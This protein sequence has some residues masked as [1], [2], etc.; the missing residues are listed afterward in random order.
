[1]FRYFTRPNRN[2]NGGYVY[3]SLLW[4][5]YE[6][7]AS[8]IVLNMWDFSKYIGMKY[9]DVDRALTSLARSN[10]INRDKRRNYLERI[11]LIDPPFKCYYPME[12]LDETFEPNDRVIP[13]EHGYAV[14]FDKQAARC[15]ITGTY[16]PEEIV[17]Q[18]GY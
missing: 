12:R 5:C 6:F 10:M 9:S 8:A 3:Y 2:P 17:R 13:F 15:R 16:K 1:M 4:L 7:R 14:E 18:K 11:S